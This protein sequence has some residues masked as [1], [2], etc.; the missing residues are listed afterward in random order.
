MTP[1]PDELLLLHGM[2]ARLTLEHVATLD[3]LLAEYEAERHVGPPAK[4][5][6]RVVYSGA[7]P[8]T[9]RAYVPGSPEEKRMRRLARKREWWKKH[10]H[11]HLLLR[12]QE[13]R[14]RRERR[15]QARN[16]A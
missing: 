7:T 16:A 5:R 9:G 13:R 2:G 14:E 1:S 4:V 11:R 10:G 15:E 3:R 12:K 8:P 6:T